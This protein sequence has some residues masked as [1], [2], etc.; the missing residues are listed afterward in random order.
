M[1]NI[2]VN[3]S[4]IVDEICSKITG[5][6]NCFEDNTIIWLTHITDDIILS[7]LLG[8]LI[9]QLTQTYKIFVCL[10]SLSDVFNI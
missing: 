9:F 10:F 7:F 3:N 5:H 4:L 1:G 6:A 8:Y 2:C